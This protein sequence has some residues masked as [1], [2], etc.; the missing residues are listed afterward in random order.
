M[1]SALRFFN[2]LRT[3]SVVDTSNISGT[4]T[5]DNAP[6][7]FIGE[8]ATA[9]GTNSP[10]TATP[11]NVTSISLTA[12]DWDVQ[13]SIQTNTGGSI[14]G[15]AVYLSTTSAAVDPGF[16]N[17]GAY[18]TL[19][20]PA[21]TNVRAPIGIARFSLAATTTVYLVSN[22]SYTVSNTNTGFIW[23]RRAR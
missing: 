17:N 3:W 19:N 16:P 1:V 8:Y 2:E 20:V 5:N 10:G 22:I 9:T 7:G 6:A 18:L 13:G 23:A 12:G 4:T 21:G 14:T 11:S 15:G